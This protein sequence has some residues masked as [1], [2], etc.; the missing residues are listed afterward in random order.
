MLEVF[1]EKVANSWNYY[2]DLNGRI[3]NLKRKLDHYRENLAI[4]KSG[5]TKFGR[6]FFTNSQSRIDELGHIFM[7]DV[8]KMSFKAGIIDGS[9]EMRFK[10]TVFRITKG[11]C[12]V[13]CIHFD[14]IFQ[15]LQETEKTKMVFF[16]LYPAQQDNYLDRKITKLV[17]TYC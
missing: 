8:T 16:V 3:D 4:I 10:R 9:D 2:H 7:K 5:E 15:G 17:Q 14:D 12:L 11:N 13:E 1:E 6:S